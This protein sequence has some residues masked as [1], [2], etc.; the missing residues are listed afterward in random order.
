[1]AIPER[2]SDYLTKAGA[3]PVRQRQSKWGEMSDLS[4][5][6][7]LYFRWAWKGILL[8]LTILGL[9]IYLACEFGAFMNKV[10]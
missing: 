7:K 3:D 5:S 9:A 6:I 1:M 10:G 4:Y 2:G 8:R